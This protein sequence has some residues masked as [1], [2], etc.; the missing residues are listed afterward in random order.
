MSASIIGMPSFDEERLFD[1]VFK[2]VKPSC[3]Y[4][5]AYGQ[6]SY[7][8][9]MCTIR[10]KNNCGAPDWLQVYSSIYLWNYCII[11]DRRAL[12]KFNRQFCQMKRNKNNRDRWQIFL[13]EFDDQ[14][15]VK[16]L[17]GAKIAE[18]INATIA[19]GKDHW[20][21]ICQHPFA[22]DKPLFRCVSIC[23]LQIDMDLWNGHIN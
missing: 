6:T 3:I 5:E 16:R 23:Q 18:L 22:N 7:D 20:F 4:V 17:F 10:V 9:H 14:V 19:H 11:V 12:G 8:K 1:F 2:D 21:E 15:K 13:D